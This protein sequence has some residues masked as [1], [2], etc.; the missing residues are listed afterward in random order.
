MF[1]KEVKNW[2][3]RYAQL[4]NDAQNKLLKE[5]YLSTFSNANA[6]VKD[7]PFV[8]LD[9]ET[10][11]LNSKTDDI[12]SVGLV[13]FTL[14]RIYCKQSKHWVVQPR[15]NLSESSIVIHGITHNDV[16]N[17]PDFDNIIAPLLD[18]LRS[19]VIVVH[20][21]AIERGFFNSA[22]LLRLKEHIEFMVVDTMELERRALKAKQGLIGQLF[23]TKLGSLRL[24][25]CRK[26]YS[27]PSYEGHHALTDALATAELLQAQLRHHYTEETPLFTIWS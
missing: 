22:L 5:F 23:N 19:K 21:A 2:N 6:S 15:R 3:T 20:Y 27:L 12:V 1:F 7:I 8:A 18:A 13:P 25:D 16:D 11:G 24:N 17:A 26:R 14:A 4:A 9:F 10:T